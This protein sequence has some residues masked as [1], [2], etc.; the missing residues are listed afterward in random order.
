MEVMDVMSMRGSSPKPVAVTIDKAT[1][2][3]L[4]HIR[5]SVTTAAETV[6]LA[7]DRAARFTLAVNEIVINAIQHGGGAATVMITTG[8]DGVVV[9]VHDAGPGLP[10][11]INP[12]RPA[13]ED[14]SGRGIWLARQLSDHV[15]ISTSDAGSV[16]RLTADGGAD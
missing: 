16:I 13:P 8:E 4:A 6:G 12:V 5:L 2:A 7:D 1:A 14:L 9:D 10:V 3:D 11:D 15:E